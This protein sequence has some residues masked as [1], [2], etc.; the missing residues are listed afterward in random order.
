MKHHIQPLL[1]E[2]YGFLFE[3]ALIEEMAEV[4]SLKE[5]EE[6][7]IIMDYGQHIKG[8]PL[9]LDG[10]LKVM[11]Q[12]SEG[13]ELVLYYLESGDVCTMTMTCC[14]GQK[15][16]E[17]RVVAEKKSTFLF[18]PIDRMKEW[19]K[20]YNSWLTFV[21]ESYDTRFNELLDAID[22]LAFNDLKER[23]VKY[24]RDKVMITKSTLLELSHQQIAY[25]MNTSRVV[26]S[27]LLKKL[28][29]EKIVKLGRNK[30][31]L[32]DF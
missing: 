6:G 7:D 20:K 2:R 26:I 10:A 21:F 8:M 29:M 31:E 16:S 18:V 3:D 22:N 23:L 9:M 28:E 15:K 24:I 1:I 14:L 32:L 25:E 13:D 17:I 5:V 27:R 12:D 19:I 4:S 30:I 11:R